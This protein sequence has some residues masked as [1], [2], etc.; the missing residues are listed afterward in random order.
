MESNSQ[1]LK[2]N[3]THK[4]HITIKELAR[5]KDLMINKADKGR[6]V[7]IIDTDNSIKESDW[8]LHDKA[9]YKQLN[10]DPTL[11]HIRNINLT[12]VRF[13]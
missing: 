12:I 11:Q 13:S 7:V 5:R 8:Q 6:V 1:R 4:E 10:E 9:N 3:L 2:S